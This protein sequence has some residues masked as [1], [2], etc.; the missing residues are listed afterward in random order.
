MEGLFPFIIIGFV[1]L[2]IA[3]AVL[4]YIQ[5]KKRREELAAWCA[6]HD[7]RFNPDRRHDF[8]HDFPD[9]KCLHAGDENRYAYNLCSGV[10]SGRRLVA[11]DYHYQTV[12][13]DSKGRRQTHSHHFSAIILD[14]ELPL[15]PLAIRPEGWFD[16]VA[17]CFGWDDIDFES[18][19]FSRSFH[20]SS[21]DRRWA[22]DV[23]H[24]RAIQFL[25]DSPR[26]TIGFDHGRVIVHSS[27]TYDV[28]TF[29]SAI[30]VAQGLLDMLPDYVRQ[31]QTTGG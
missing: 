3:I 5:A 26:Y 20:V 16:K 19:E 11:F 14:A 9:F 2:F 31:A 4:G 12:S 30:A 17:Q 24:P 21:P 25:L 22:Y 27:G 28:A 13:R 15:R 23:L 29:E 18:A 7:L 1:V 8:R 6:R 10:W